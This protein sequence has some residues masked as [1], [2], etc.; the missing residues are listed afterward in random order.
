MHK[1]G[2]ALIQDLEE[3]FSVHYMFVTIEKIKDLSWFMI[4]YDFY[5]MN[6]GFIYPKPWQGD[7]IHIARLIKI[8]YYYKS[9]DIFLSCLNPVFIC[10]FLFYRIF[11]AKNNV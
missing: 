8:K 5:P 1:P 3:W 9:I 6:Y 11:Y 10:E 4:L 2:N 7:K